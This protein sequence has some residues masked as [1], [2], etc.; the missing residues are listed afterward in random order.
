MLVILGVCITRPVPLSSTCSYK[1][2]Q[3]TYQSNIIVILPS[4]SNLC[5]G[6]RWDYF[7]YAEVDFPYSIFTISEGLRYIIIEEFTICCGAIIGRQE[8]YKQIKNIR[9]E[10]DCFCMDLS[11]NIIECHRIWLHA[12]RRDAIWRDVWLHGD[13][14]WVRRLSGTIRTPTSNRLLHKSVRLFVR[15]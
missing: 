11:L 6:K 4:F 10:T 5:W 1:I 13:N 7:C 15:L 3:Y 9:R 8:L 2:F 14:I 12:S